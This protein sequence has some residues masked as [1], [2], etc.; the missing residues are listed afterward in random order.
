M[1]THFQQCYRVTVTLTRMARE[2]ALLPPDAQAGDKL[3]ATAVTADDLMTAWTSDRAVLSMV[4]KSP[5]QAGALSAGK[6]V[7]RAMGSWQ[8]ATVEAEALARS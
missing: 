1:S 7:A 8:G 5:C 4:I 6:A 3:A 2:D